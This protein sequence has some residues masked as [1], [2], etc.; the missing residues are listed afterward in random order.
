[1]MFAQV[2]IDRQAYSL[3]VVAEKACHWRWKVIRR[4]PINNYLKPHVTEND[5]PVFHKSDGPNPIYG[6]EPKT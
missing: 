2:L 3:K 1:M 6:L 4:P 5:L